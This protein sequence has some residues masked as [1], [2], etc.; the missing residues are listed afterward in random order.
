LIMQVD[1]KNGREPEPRWGTVPEPLRTKW[2]GVANAI[3]KYYYGPEVAQAAIRHEQV[4]MELDSMVICDWV[5]GKEAW[6]GV[7]EL[8]GRPNPSVQDAPDTPNMGSEYWNAVTGITKTQ[9]E[10]YENYDMLRNL[11]RAIL[12]REGYRSKDDQFF[13]WFHQLKDEH[14]K[15]VCPKED[16][17]K[18]KLEYYRQRGWDQ[19]TGIPLKSTLA[20]KGLQDV[21][22]ELERRGVP[23]K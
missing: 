3:R 10:L 2:L 19:Q 8:H 15:I 9:E 23:L 4:G 18:L 17:N 7:R 6:W 5:S 11:E 14:G 13:D 20:A 1:V 22:D 16:F 12:A 21:A